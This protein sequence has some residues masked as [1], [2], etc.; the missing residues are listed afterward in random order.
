MLRNK[1]KGMVDIFE[2]R[3][4]IIKFEICNFVGKDYLVSGVFKV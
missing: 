1:S 4:L 2:I 3:N